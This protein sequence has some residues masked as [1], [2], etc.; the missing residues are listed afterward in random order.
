MAILTPPTMAI[1]RKDIWSDRWSA[2]HLIEVIRDTPAAT[3]YYVGCNRFYS[4][5]EIVEVKPIA[6]ILASGICKTC[7]GPMKAEDN[8]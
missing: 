6:D 2:W 3:Y 1:R 8:K 7:L 4:S 5:Q